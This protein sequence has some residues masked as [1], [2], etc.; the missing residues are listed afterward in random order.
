MT[1]I[2]KAQSDIV[3]FSLLIVQKCP[4][5][6][7]LN[8]LFTLVEFV[9]D[10]DMKTNAK[11]PNNKDFRLFEILSKQTNKTQQ[12]KEVHPLHY[13]DDIKLN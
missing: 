8:K 13:V 2:L 12:K 10:C 4:N 3:N 9:F 7:F 1:E 6:T 11:T 5:M